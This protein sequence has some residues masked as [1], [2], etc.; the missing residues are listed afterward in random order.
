[1]YHL[2]LCEQGLNNHHEAIVLFDK[3]I[4]LKKDFVEAYNQK[5]FS[6]ENSIN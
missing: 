1:M 6:Y 5:G 4:F 2:A 3:V